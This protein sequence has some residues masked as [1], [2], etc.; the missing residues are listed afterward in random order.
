MLLDCGKY[1]PDIYNNKELFRYIKNTEQHETGH[2]QL[3]PYLLGWDGNAYE[4]DLKY[5]RVFPGT[6]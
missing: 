4:K 5:V 6:H 1:T 3:C 2:L